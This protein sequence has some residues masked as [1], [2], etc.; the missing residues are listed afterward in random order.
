MP[1][2]S[3]YKTKHNRGIYF[4]FFGI[5][6]GLVTLVAISSYLLYQREKN[7]TSQELSLQAE[8][9]LDIIEQFIGN[10]FNFVGKDLVYLTRNPAFTWYLYEE[11]E[12][13]R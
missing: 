5:V 4:T 13:S 6:T 10:E 7:Q 3:K 2:K 1:E 12:K 11:D 9:S 8:K